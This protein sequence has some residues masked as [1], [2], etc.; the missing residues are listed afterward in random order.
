MEQ[1][2][3]NTCMRTISNNRDIVLARNM[4]PIHLPMLASISW[5]QFK[6]NNNQQTRTQHN[7]QKNG[8]KTRKIKVCANSISFVPH[9]VPGQGNESAERLSRFTTP[10][11][12]I[13]LTR[14]QRFEATE[15]LRKGGTDKIRVET[16]RV[17]NP[18][19]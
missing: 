9:H 18:I 7:Q 11:N 3:T 8:T 5:K 17:Q 14:Q 4:N 6:R 13:D 2:N 12:A 10:L 19:N 16:K 1:C 15:K